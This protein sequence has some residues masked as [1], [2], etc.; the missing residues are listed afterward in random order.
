MV[1][2]EPQAVSPT[3]WLASA[4]KGPQGLSSETANPPINQAPTR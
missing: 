3:L 1:V 2:R 4:G